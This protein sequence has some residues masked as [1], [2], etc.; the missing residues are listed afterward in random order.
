[1]IKYIFGLLTQPVKTWQ[2][3]HDENLSMAQILIP[4]L[5]LA[6]IPPICGYIGTTT[7]GWSIGAGDPIKLHT[8][9]AL[10]MAIL[11]YL[12][13][14]AAIVSVAMM[15][16]WMGQT[17]GADQPLNRCLTL[18]VFIPV[19]LLLIGVMQLYPVLWINLVVALPA[20]AYSIM[21]LYT[22]IPIMME[23]PKERGFMFSSAV[24]GF[25]LVGLVGMLVV[26]VIL[27]GNGLE[28]VFVS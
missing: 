10:T 4:V 6:A 23:I 24:L 9:G 16:R 3:L 8:D 14:L 28:P 2:K 5:V 25:G 26:T 12:A 11:Y 20:L 27:W 17:Y 1:M 18:S 15:I 19:P 21:L 22:G 13:I 7:T